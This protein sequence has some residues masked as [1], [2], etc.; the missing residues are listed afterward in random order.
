MGYYLISLLIHIT[1]IQTHM[2]NIFILIETHI[3]ETK[4][5]LDFDSVIVIECILIA[6]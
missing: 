4:Q 2:Q 1:G 3:N 6:F 5:N